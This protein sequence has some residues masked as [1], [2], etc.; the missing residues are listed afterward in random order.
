M[1]MA[2]QREITKRLLAH[3][4]NNTTEYAPHWVEYP[5]DRYFSE[6]RFRLEKEH[7]F[8]RYPLIVALS[9]D[10]PEPLS[11][12]AV[13][14]TPTPILLVRGDEG[15]LRAFANVCRHR[16]MKVASGCGS[17]ARRFSCPF[18]NWTYDT[19]GRLVGVPMADG[20]RGMSRADHG[21]VALPVVER[22][23]LIVVSCRPGE[24]IDADAYFGSLGP[25]LDSW[26]FSNFR[27]VGDYDVHPMQGNWKVCWDTFNETYHVPCLH[28]TTLARFTLGNCLTV[29]MFGPHVRMATPAHSLVEL[30]KLPEHKWESIKHVSYQYRMLPNSA[31][32]ITFDALAHYQ[33]FP[34][35]RPDTCVAIRGVY[36]PRAASDEAAA[37]VHERWH[38]FWRDVIIPEDFSVVEASTR[39]LMSGVTPSTVYGANEP[40]MIHLHEQLERII[41]EGMAR[42]RRAP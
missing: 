32:T 30:D 35:P 29:D 39:G 7:V 14:W 22:H 31:F 38:G 8:G 26:K 5:A 3:Y 4:H 13:D 37:A 27:M 42:E 15:E 34:G 33:V 18:H 20:F 40:A 12:K 19:S 9:C 36:V 10:V 2:T 25:D 41:T 1:D 28:G 21:L 11:W 24:E 17:G 6:E 23:G 16:G